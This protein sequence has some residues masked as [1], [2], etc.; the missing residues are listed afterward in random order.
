MDTADLWKSLSSYLEVTWFMVNTPTPIKRGDTFTMRFRINNTSAV[1]DSSG[2]D[3]PLV[4][5][6][7]VRLSV[8]GTGYA[9]PTSGTEIEI[10][11]PLHPGQRSSPF[12]VHFKAERD[13]AEPWDLF[14]EEPV[15]ATIVHADVDQEL[16]FRFARRTR[17]NLGSGS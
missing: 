2:T 10:D 11:D 14:R 8:A 4:V 17:L 1:P 9:R 7:N 16:F 15:A 5:F 12:L 3:T 6:K 13:M